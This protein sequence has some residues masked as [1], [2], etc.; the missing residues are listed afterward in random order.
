MSTAHHRSLTP[1]WIRLNQA[2][3][4]HVDAEDVDEFLDT[5]TMIA[6]EHDRHRGRG[7]GDAY[8]EQVIR[9]LTGGTEDDPTED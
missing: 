3:A 8:L 2:I 9:S 5:V 7:A 4:A 1:I 6:S